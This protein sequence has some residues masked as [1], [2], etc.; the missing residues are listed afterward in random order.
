MAVEKKAARLIG[1]GR[2]SLEITL[3][4][5]GDREGIDYEDG[6]QGGPW[7][8]GRDQ[9]WEECFVSLCASSGKTDAD[10]ERIRQ[11]ISEFLYAPEDQITLDV[12]TGKQEAPRPA[13]KTELQAALDDA[14][15]L[16]R[17]LVKACFALHNTPQHQLPEGIT[18]IDNNEVHVRVDGHTVVA[19]VKVPQS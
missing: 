12:R 16:R 11:A 8:K 5:D 3:W 13:P 19:R 4:R 6:Y 2:G 18:L 7:S 17:A 1:A 15:W 10:K 9:T 14:Q